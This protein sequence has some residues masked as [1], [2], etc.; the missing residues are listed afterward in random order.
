MYTHN[1]LIAGCEADTL[2]ALEWT[3]G[4]E[5][6]VFSAT[7]EEEALAVMERNEIALIIVDHRM[8]GMTGIEFLEKTQEKYPDVTRVF[9][10]TSTDENGMADAIDKGHIHSYMTEP[11]KT[12][13]LLGVTKEGLEAYETTRSNRDMY[14]R[15]LLN[16]GV[17][18]GE[19]LNEALQEQKVRK[20]TIAEVLVEYDMISQS[21]LDT[22]MTVRESGQEQLGEILIRLG[23]VSL[24]ELEMAYELQRHSRRRLTEILV[25]LG[26]ADEET[27]SSC[28][29][30]Q[31]GMPFVSISEFSIKPEVIGMLPSELAYRY[32]VVPIDSVGR[33]LVIAASEPLNDRAKN[34]IEQETGYKVMAMCTSYRDIETTLKRRYKHSVA[35][36]PAFV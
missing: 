19:Q 22:A 34:E 18:T 8:S 30:L 21:E 28:Y 33:V 9:L 35:K 1:I 36:Y 32:S 17:I 20:K 11:R 7:S 12:R 3:L 27:I 13:E 26:Y 10:T 31:L 2:D 29:A 15:A 24:E 23:S 25:D 14:A 16:T 4:Q 5:Y 6:N